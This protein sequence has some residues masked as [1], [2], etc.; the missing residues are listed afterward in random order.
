MSIVYS[1]LHHSDIPFSKRGEIIQRKIKGIQIGGVAPR[2]A[3]AGGAAPRG[4]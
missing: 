2:R 1:T 4:E 3:Q